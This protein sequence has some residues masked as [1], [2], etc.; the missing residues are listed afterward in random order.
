MF[1]TAL[2]KELTTLTGNKKLIEKLLA[3]I[4][5]QYSKSN[6]HYHNLAHLESLYSNLLGVA[7]KIN[8]WQII[9]LSIAYH[10]IVY[11]THKQ[12]NEEKSAQ[13][14]RS[15]LTQIGLSSTKIETCCS[16]ILATKGHS[17]SIDSDTN[18]F[19]DADLSVLGTS[20]AIYNEYKKAIRKEY[21]F[22]P[23]FLYNPGRKKVLAH[24]LS[25]PRIYKTEYFFNRCETEA[26]ANIQQELKS[27]D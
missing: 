15:R 21:K 18:Y 5:Q 17:I 10:D 11:N 3:E 20:E 2:Q 13:L 16:Q 9:L 19:T 14:A 8:D 24:F 25:M 26:R 27:F 23:E 1:K 6:R 7:D 12:D 4:V 22:Y